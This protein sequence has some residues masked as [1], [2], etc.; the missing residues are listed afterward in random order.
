MPAAKRSRV[1]S[2]RQNA[3]SS[4]C[5]RGDDEFASSSLMHA[6]TVQPGKPQS[7]RL[8][9]VPAPPLS[10]GAVCVR[11]LALGICGTDREIIDGHYGWAPPGEAR[12]IIGHES[13]GR[14]RRGAGR[15][16]L[17]ARR[18]GGRH[19]AA[20][21]SGAVPGLRRRRMGHVP[22]RRNIPSAASS[23]ATAMAAKQF[24]VEP[25]F[26]VKVDPA[27]GDA[28]RAAG[29]DERGRQGLGA[30]RCASARAAPPGSR[31]RRW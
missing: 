31:A 15:L 26:L 2:A 27:L 10:D 6:L 28:R 19:R 16:R 1:E 7:I 29:A 8:D 11:A 13:F 21:R 18:S 3:S 25:D 24:R 9:D 14:G 22:Q 30:G 23:S 20:A 12:L 4:K 5:R 17:Q